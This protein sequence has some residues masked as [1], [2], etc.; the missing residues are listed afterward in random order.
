[1]NVGRTKADSAFYGYDA[2]GNQTSRPGATIAYTAFDLPKQISLTRGDTVDFAYDGLQQRGRKTTAAQELVS[3]GELYER[4]TDVV[5]G[6]VEHRY[7]VRN[8]ERVV[9]LVRRSTA[10]GTRTLHV[11]V[12]HLGSIDVLTDGVTG[13]V[14]EQR[15]YDA[16]GAPRHPDWGSGQLPSPHELSSL[17]FT[18]HE[19]DLDLGLVNMTGRLYDPKLGRFLTPDPLVPRPLFGQSW[20]AYSYVLN[21]PL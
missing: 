15:S 3:F 19:A 8:D 12:D 1:M 20:N 6:T 10:Q 7:H 5:T 9:S 13:S 11:H 2:V 18:G 14:A 4:V 17:G 21:S 16:F